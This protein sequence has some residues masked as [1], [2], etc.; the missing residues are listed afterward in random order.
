[1][2]QG[3]SL[4]LLIQAGQNFM[5]FMTAYDRFVPS[6]G[7]C[8][9]TIVGTNP[10]T[11]KDFQESIRDLNRSQDKIIREWGFDFSASPYKKKRNLYH[12]IYTGEQNDLLYEDL[13]DPCMLGRAAY[14]KYKS[15]GVGKFSGKIRRHEL[16]AISNKF[17]NRKKVYDRY[18]KCI[19]RAFYSMISGEC[20]CTL[21]K[22][23]EK[24]ICC[25]SRGV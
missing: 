22:E 16:V 24:C 14:V 15:G 5:K 25:G 17:E 1:M 7:I 9:P 18:Y 3:T 21:H 23:R 4:L 2:L 20:D 11:E 13:N 12:V 6:E 8:G 19:T 10:T